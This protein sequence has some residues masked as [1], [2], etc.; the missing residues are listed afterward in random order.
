MNELKGFTNGTEFSKIYVDYKCRNIKA[1]TQQ[2]VST[3]LHVSR[4]NKRVKEL[5]IQVPG[6]YSWEFLVGMCRPVLQILT[7]FQTKKILFSTPL[8]RPDL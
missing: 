6:G 5:D 7:L 3:N 4:L 1:V 8:L 2:F